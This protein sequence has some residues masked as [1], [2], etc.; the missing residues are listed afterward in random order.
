MDPGGI[1]ACERIV[2]AEPYTTI[3]AFERD[4]EHRACLV[5]VAQLLV[6]CAQPGVQLD[7]DP[8]L[9]RMIGFAEE[10]DLAR[11]YSI[12]SVCRPCSADRWPARM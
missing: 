4:R 7:E 2:R 11:E 10:I 9:Q 5:S 8:A 3:E 1:V 12:A 6:R